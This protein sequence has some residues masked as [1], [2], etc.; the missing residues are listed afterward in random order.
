MHEVGIIEELIKEFE[1]QSK[2]QNA[3]R[4]TKIIGSS[5]KVVVIHLK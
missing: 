3:Y 2:A 4:V 1:S 5:P